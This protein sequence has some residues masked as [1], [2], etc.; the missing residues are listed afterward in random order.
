MRHKP[1]PRHWL[2]VLLL[3]VTLA[4]PAFVVGF[5]LLREHTPEPKLDVLV[6]LTVMRYIV[7]GDQSSDV[8]LLSAV[9]VTNNGA[10]NYRNVKI[11]LN[12]QFFYDH[13]KPLP[14]SESIEIPL[15]FFVTK[16]GSVKFQTGN[17]KVNQVTVFAQIENNSR[18]V[19]ER[20]FDDAGKPKAEVDSK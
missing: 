3:A 13:P 6:E 7:E 18:A 17:K 8:R 12:K 15:E 16:G 14:Q 2:I 11:L 19:A 4:P 9:K 20:Y 5:F 10:G 1:I